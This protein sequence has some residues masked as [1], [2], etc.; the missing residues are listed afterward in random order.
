M[1]LQSNV[2]Q[3]R[4]NSITTCLTAAVKTLEILA[5]SLKSPFLATISK[6]TLSLVSI[7]ESVR[8][9]KNDCVQLMEQIHTLLYAIISLHVKS[10]TEGVLSPEMLYHLGKFTETLHKIHT[11]VE[12]QQYKSRIKHFFRQAEINM[13]LKDCNH[14]LGQALE[15]FK[16][17]NAENME[18]QDGNLIKDV[19]D[20]QGYAQAR[21]QEVLEMIECL[22]D[23]TSS[24]RASSITR[25][26]STSNSSH[27]ISM[28]PSEPKIF[29][30]REMELASII[31]LLT[32]DTPRIAILGAGGMGKT[33]LAKAVLHYPDIA[34]RYG[35]H[36]CLLILD[37]LETLWEP[38]KTRGDI[39]EFLSLLTDVP[40]LS[41]IITMRGDER[42]AKVKWTRPFLLPLKPLSQDAAYKTFVDNADDGHDR[43]DV[44]KVL[45]LTN[46][47]PLAIELLAHLVDSE[48]C[49]TVLTRWE[50]EK[51][52]LISEGS[53]KRSNLDLSISLSLTS[54]RMKSLP[55]SQQLL[56][57]LSLLPDG[58]SD[59]ELL[60]SK[61][62]IQD[63]LNCKT[64]LI[65]TSLA[66][67]DDQKRLKTLVPIQ[68]Y[69]K[70]TC[71][72]I[73]N[74]V[75]ALLGHFQE[76]LKLY[77]S[78]V[79]TAAASGIFTR[80]LSNRANIH[81]LLL[82]GLHKDTPDLVNTIYS[83]I[84]LA[85][86]NQGAG[87]GRIPL[88]D[89]V[90]KLLPPTNYNLE[91][92][93]IHEVIN[94]WRWNP[95]CD[96]ESL[97]QQAVKHIPYVDDSDIKWNFYNVLGGYHRSHGNFSTAINFL[98]TGLSFTLENK[99][100]KA[101]IMDSLGWIEFRMGDYHAAKMHAHEA[102]KL[103]KMA[104]SLI[105]EVKA[106]DLEARCWYALGHYKHAMSLCN[107]AT[108]LLDLCGMSGSALS[109]Q[110]WNI[111]V[112]VH[113]LKSE[114]EEAHNIQ[115]QILDNVTREQDPYHHSMAALNMAELDVAI[116][117]P[118]HD[119]QW[120]IEIAR[121]GLTVMKDLVGLSWCD[122]I[123]ATLYL[124]EGSLGTAKSL[125]QTCAKFAQGTDAEMEAYCQERLG[126]I[127]CWSDSEWT[128]TWVT[129]FL[130]NAFKSKQKLQI[131]QAL[132]LCGNVF[133][134]EGDQNTA[135]SLF[136]IALEGF[137]YMDVHQSRAECM[138]RLGDISK[139]QG[140]LLKAVG[141]WDSARPL[142]ERS[143][144]A[145]KVA[146]IHERLTQIPEIVLEEHK[147]GLTLLT[148]LHG[149]TMAL[150]D[151][152]IG[153]PEDENSVMDN[154]RM[155][156]L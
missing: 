67:C 77:Q 136:T 94:S 124:R 149:P 135:L 156:D 39:E 128:P 125:L 122:V 64:T 54:P 97:I 117:R 1:P 69:M 37:N 2:T 42:P 11:F 151:L 6:T 53:N 98:Q 32:K 85:R 55:Q 99:K 132:R 152:D 12:A 29:H 133:H 27:S 60:Q 100:G 7:V 44:D 111:Q 130:V 127:S 155:L 121:S 47:M 10:E 107:E 103:F 81:N 4:L 153:T 118:K 123:Q 143:S 23:I 148:E 105:G 65:R 90:P 141:F 109:R 86:I 110:L 150:A 25:L 72:P 82:I 119:V 92:Y 34:A 33:T 83:A 80:I 46:N 56:S 114:F 154:D 28:L 101:E 20:L 71:P 79:G 16:R 102:W 70:K 131:Y 26:I 93:F 45:L 104:P 146:Q 63:I 21:H 91:L 5:D 17:L 145:K 18:V 50:N 89:V 13:L 96:L 57:L 66:H 3:I 51:T 36:S 147:K 59:V 113:K 31:Q 126:D 38:A 116:D 30:G 48:G 14:R 61:L 134:I 129:V 74:L 138:L 73:P 75:Q 52:S 144:Q 120:N 62:P 9:N 41:L 84:R 139:M 40:Q 19:K 106:L 58:L 76:L 8:Q 15:V 22:F 78:Y 140:D 87:F 137:T 142:F 112:E 43:T 108:S 95:K 68:E 115:I 24:D 49:S 35:E 88:M